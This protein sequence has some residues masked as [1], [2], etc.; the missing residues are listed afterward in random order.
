MRDTTT[1]KYC[2]KTAK[3]FVS[4]GLLLWFILNRT[5]KFDKSKEVAALLEQQ[6][7]PSHA[8]H[9]CADD[10]STK[11]IY[12]LYREI[13]STHLKGTELGTLQ[14]LEKTRIPPESRHSVL[15]YCAQTIF[16]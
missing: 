11:S 6:L 4:L 13:V 5:E 7:V 15:I 3:N 16:H 14:A 8:Q 1:R 2:G 12:D 9:P 10:S